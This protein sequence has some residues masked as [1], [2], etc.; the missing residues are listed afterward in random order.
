MKVRIIR[1]CAAKGQHLEEGKEYDFDD[2]TARDLVNA[3]R[4]VYLGAAQI[5]VRDPTFAIGDAAD[6][7]IAPP[8]TRGKS[9]A[10]GSV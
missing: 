1:T 10:K 8:P 4:A 3:R 9:K 7:L 6:T 5:E 2:K